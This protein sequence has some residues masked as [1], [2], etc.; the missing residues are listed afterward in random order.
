MAKEYISKSLITACMNANNLNKYEEIKE[1]VKR[2]DDIIRMSLLMITVMVTFF[3]LSFNIQIN[4]VHTY[5]FVAFSL[6]CWIFGHALGSID[7]LHLGSEVSA[8]LFSWAFL[9]LVGSSTFLKYSSNSAILGISLS[10][11]A[12]IIELVLTYPVYKW[13]KGAMEASEQNRF[14]KWLFT[15]NASIMLAINAQYLFL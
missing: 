14:K 1:R 8:K 2:F 7:R 12:L 3:S 6:A 4:L 13:L 9:I 15:I 10:A 11:L 5:F